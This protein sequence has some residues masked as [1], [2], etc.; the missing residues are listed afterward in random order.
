MSSFY[1]VPEVYQSDH[2]GGKFLTQAIL[3][4]PKGWKATVSL[5]NNSLVICPQKKVLSLMGY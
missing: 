1:L 3:K 5:M 2:A 4:D